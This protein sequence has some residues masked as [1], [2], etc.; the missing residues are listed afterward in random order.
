MPLYGIA[1]L[2]IEI[3]APEW[4]LH[5]NLR[6]FLG[7]IGKADACCSVVFAKRPSKPGIDAKIIATTPGTLVYE[8]Q[9][10]IHKLSGD[11]NDIPSYTVASLNCSS[12]QMYIDPEYN[13]PDDEAVVQSIREGLLASLRDFIISLLARNNGLIIHSSSIIF[14]D[15]GLLFSAPSGTGKSTHTHL[16]R[17]YYGTPILDGDA[18]ACRLINGKPVVYGL[19]WCGTSGEFL[20]SS[21]P[22]AAVIF[23]QQA[24]ENRIKKLD[25]PEAVQRLISR[26]FLQP[27]NEELMNSYLA[28]AEEIARKADCYLLECLPEREAV[29]L[30]KKCLRIQ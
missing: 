21:A 9:S 30:V 16:W 22:L 15:K 18:T 19:P 27:W 5:D 24:K 20:N 12:Y 29:E 6:L 2:T 11:E 4:A 17:Q 1:G 8:Q 28:I 26:C 23:L 13:T 25:L 3:A 14:Q 10:S 7:G